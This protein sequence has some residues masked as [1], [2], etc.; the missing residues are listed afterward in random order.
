LHIY[1]IFIVYFKPGAPM[2]LREMGDQAVLAEIGERINRQRL[3]RN[4]TQVDLARRAGVTRI[5]VQRLENGHGCNLESLVK[6][7]RSL[8]LIDQLDSFL[9][10]PGIS[11]VQLAKFRGNERLRASRPGKKQKAG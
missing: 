11:P 9:P 2:D 8:D 1:S 3:N 4:I 6:V 5:V 7:L 10:R